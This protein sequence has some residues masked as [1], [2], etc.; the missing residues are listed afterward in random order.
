MARVNGGFNGFEDRKRHLQA[1]LRV[2]KV[3]SCKA[4][5]VGGTYRPFEDRDIYNNV[6]YVFAW[7][8]WNDA[9]SGKKGVLGSIE[10]RRKGYSRFI[11]LSKELSE[12]V[13]KVNRF[14]MW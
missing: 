11:Q 8:C 4:V 6:T 5:T 2:L 1:A 9:K 10:E 14:N 13:R 7:G 3:K 12:K